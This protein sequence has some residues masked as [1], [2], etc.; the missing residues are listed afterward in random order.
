[1]T[2]EAEDNSDRQS[3]LRGEINRILLKAKY[4]IYCTLLFFLFANPYT[5]EVTS[6]WLGSMM[7]V[8]DGSGRP[9]P[10]GFGLHLIL[11][12]LTLW[13]LMLTPA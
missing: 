2:K 1:M 5:Y 10:A 3:G 6:T 9:T 4:A 11:F 7:T 8:L 13:G 12:F